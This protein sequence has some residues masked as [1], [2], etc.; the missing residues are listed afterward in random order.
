[1][2]KCEKQTLKYFQRA[3]TKNGNADKCV[4]QDRQIAFHPSKVS[5]LT[6]LLNSKLKN[7]ITDSLG[8]HLVWKLKT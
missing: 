3:W 6:V 8:I 2:R 5:Y 1:M 7:Q 4:I